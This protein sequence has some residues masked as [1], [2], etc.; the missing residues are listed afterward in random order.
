MANTEVLAVHVSEAAFLWRHRERGARAP[1]FD[2]VHLGRLDERL[3]AHLQALALAG[4]TGRGLAEQALGDGDSAAL[5]VAAWLACA[6]ADAASLSHLAALAGADAAHAVALAAALTWLP[7][8]KTGTVVRSL[9]ASPAPVHRAIGLRVLLNRR[10]QPSGDL[11]RYLADAAAPVRAMAAGLAG[12][13][14]RTQDLAALRQ[15]LGDPD[16]SVYLA[17][18]RALA[19]LGDAD[20]P[21]ALAQCARSSPQAARA[22]AP[23]LVC[24]LDP[25]AA[26][27]WIQSLTQQRSTLRLG[28]RAAGMF[29]DTRVADWLLALM[30]DPLHARLAG[31]AFAGMT[32]ADL[33]PLALRR[34]PP[35]GH[36]PDADPFADEDAD[37]GWPDPHKLKDWWARHRQGMP[38]GRRHQCGRPVSVEHATH[39][40]RHGYQRQRA[41]AAIELAWLSAPAME[42]PVRAPGPWQRQR[43]AA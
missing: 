9:L 19:L 35:E 30:D 18:A 15:L 7:A 8:D 32:G 5:F 33:D 29:G 13:L 24:S 22:A 20:G 27:A 6:H 34:D 28:I 43:L 38:A 41:Q 23:L 10:M 42:F 26:R 14:K 37:L 39:V 1:H 17:A 21:A 40:L 31:E 3:E 4:D 36:D 12:T 2:L 16:P 11:A 25:A